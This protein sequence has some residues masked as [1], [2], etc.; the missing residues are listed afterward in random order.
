MV[1]KSILLE[2]GKYSVASVRDMA[3]ARPASGLRTVPSR[4]TPAEE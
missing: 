2:F 4:A 1:L 3:G